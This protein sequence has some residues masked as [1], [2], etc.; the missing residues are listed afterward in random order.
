MIVESLYDDVN[1][2]YLI[3]DIA[4][5]LIKECDKITFPNK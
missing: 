5:L 2:Y 3:I 4:C 1:L